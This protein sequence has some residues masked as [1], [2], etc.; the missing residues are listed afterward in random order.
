MEEARRKGLRKGPASASERISRASGLPMTPRLA[1]YYRG[2]QH[3][4]VL[5]STTC[6]LNLLPS[7]PFPPPLRLPLW[8]GFMNLTKPEQPLLGK[9][10]GR[11][12]PDAGA[13][14]FSP[15]FFHSAFVTRVQ[16]P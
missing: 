5:K 3:H 16:A 11:A 7:H 12:A 10:S 4:I 14:V 13:I 8:Q 2:Q 6:C 9:G 15:S 1:C